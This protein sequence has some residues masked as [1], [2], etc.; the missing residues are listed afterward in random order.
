MISVESPLGM[1]GE[2]GAVPRR[3]LPSIAPSEDVRAAMAIFQ[4]NTLRAELIRDLALHPEGSTT[5]ESASRLD[6]DYRVVYQ[7]VQVLKQEGLL[8]LAE[9]DGS[10]RGPIYLLDEQALESRNRAFI[11]H[12]LGRD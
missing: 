2:N 12:L 6:V 10:R 7:H 1:V 11:R 3:Y 9:A 8:R 4:V 5:V